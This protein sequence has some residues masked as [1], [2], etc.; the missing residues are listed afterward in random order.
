MVTTLHGRSSDDCVL[1]FFGSMLWP[2]VFAQVIS[3]QPGF[4]PQECGALDGGR[5]ANVWE[6]AKAPELRAYCDLLAS[7]ASKLAGVQGSPREVLQ[8]ADEADKK[9]PGKLAPSVLRGRAFE[10]LRRYDDAFATLSGVRAKDPSA[11]E[12]A[13][14]LLAF[15]RS[16]VRTAHPKEA[17]EAY[18]A[19]LP[20]AV[21][22][23]AAD[24]SAAYVEA[25]FVLMSKGPSGID[26]AVA[27]FRQARKEAQDAA[28][29][30]AWLG[31]ALA[32]DRAGNRE[33]ARAVLAE[34]GKIDAR[35]ALQ[36]AKTRDLIAQPFALETEAMVALSVERTDVAQ[37][38]EA[39]KRYIEGGL[40]SAW[41]EHAKSSDASLG[42]RKR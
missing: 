29:T 13:S 20:R 33:E 9:M 3:A 1:L 40:Q 21:A 17:E 34:R 5:A 12:D 28:Q 41:L 15:A 10:R 16:A 8:I 2:L 37:A 38:H 4:R 22:L 18:H 25:A 24:R 30:V 7:G 11:L 31:L 36:D 32:L 26:E 42:R 19:L 35:S 23:P 6:R 14:A 27:I 39:W